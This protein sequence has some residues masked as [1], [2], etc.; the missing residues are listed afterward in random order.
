[1][2]SY[3]V[4]DGDYFK[5]S[6]YNKL[7]D[8]I[9]PIGSIIMWSK[10][11]APDEW[12]ICDGSTISRIVYSDLFALIAET[13]G[14]GD[15][16]NTFNLPDMRERFAIG[17]SVTYALATT[18]GGTLTISTANMYQHQ[19]SITNESAHVHQVGLQGGGSGSS[20]FSGGNSGTAGNTYTLLANA[21]HSHGGA[22]GSVGSGTA[23]TILPEYI[24]LVYIIKY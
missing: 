22:T 1:M 2:E 14:A 4:A 15:G 11:T 3:I 16:I 23:I 18:G 17:K 20:G 5:A 13:F 19:H 6:E 8:D 9:M 21:A 7:R 12:L 24:A 10:T